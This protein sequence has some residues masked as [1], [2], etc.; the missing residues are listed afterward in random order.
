MI[1]CFPT[2]NSGLRLL[3]ASLITASRCWHGV[4]D[5]TR[6]L[7]GTG[8]AIDKKVCEHLEFKILR[9]MDGKKI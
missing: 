4:K 1:L 2:E 5:D 6:Y 7:V 9:R 3:Y 8:G